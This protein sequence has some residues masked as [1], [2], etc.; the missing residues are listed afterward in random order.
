MKIN[1][2]TKFGRIQSISPTCILTKQW[3]LDIGIIKE[4]SYKFSKLWSKWC[5]KIDNKTYSFTGK[6]NKIEKIKYTLA[7]YNISVKCSAKSLYRFMKN[8][9]ITGKFKSVRQIM[10][11]R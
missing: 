1:N 4:K 6:L 5:I 9:R 10:T 7:G 3:F 11:E 2:L 8:L